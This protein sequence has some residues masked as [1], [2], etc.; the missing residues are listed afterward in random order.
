MM[1]RMKVSIIGAA[2]LIGIGLVMMAVALGTAGIDGLDTAPCVT[3]IYEIGDDFRDLDISGD[4]ANVSLV[5]SED[6][7]C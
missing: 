4:T 7:V 6:G 2:V 3:N 1:R 5:P